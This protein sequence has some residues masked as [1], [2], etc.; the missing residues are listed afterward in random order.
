MPAKKFTPKNR[1]L[2]FI[3]LIFALSF[4]IRVY[5]LEAENI[6]ADEGLTIYNAHLPISHNIKWS[7]DMAYFPLYHVILSLWEKIFGLHAFSMRFLSVIF[8]TLSVYMTYQLGSLMFNRRIG[9]CSAVIMALSPFNVYY[10]QEA[11]VYSLFVLLSLLSIYYYFKYTHSYE[12]K[13]LLMYGI[14]TLLML[15][16]HAAAIFVLIFQN[17]YHLLF[18]RK[19]FKKW[20]FT[21]SIVFILFLPLLYLVIDRMMEL[22]DYLTFSKPNLLTLIRTFYM[23]SSGTTYKLES[24]IIGAA[25]SIIFSLLILLSLF[26]MY[27]EI[28][29]ENYLKANKL[30]FLFL[31]LSVPPLLLTLQ[32]YIFYSLYLDRYV[33]ASSVAL[34]L[35]AAFSISKLKDRARLVAFVC[36]ILLSLTILCIDFETFNKERWE[37]AANYIR[38]NKNKEDAVIIHIPNAVYPFTYYFDLNCFESKNLSNCTSSQNIYAAKNA[39]DLPTEITKNNRVFL[40]LFNAK[41]MDTEGTLL[42]YFSSNYN[43]IEEKSY[44]HIQIFTFKKSNA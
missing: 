9:L 5:N 18:I 43:L 8:G 10:S 26:S 31:W 23:F 11:R 41:Y 6:W 21:Q 4:I 30:F 29:N 33:I 44:P 24:L 16:S 27:K 42:E 20:I 13:H 25:L 14:F 32:S 17:C 7:L 28:K 15:N 1:L 35:I 38:S 2:F 39:D 37:D 3:I 36:I 40:V 12:N 34:Y 19:Y 22:S